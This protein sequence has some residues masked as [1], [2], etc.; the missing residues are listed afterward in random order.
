[1]SAGPR[2]HVSVGVEQ[3]GAELG[4]ITA[5]VAPEELLHIARIPGAEGGAEGG[6]TV[7]ISDG[8][9]VMGEGRGHRSVTLM[10]PVTYRDVR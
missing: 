2:S 9:G 3:E 8:G 4:R 1:M 7:N 10:L 6:Q 5:I